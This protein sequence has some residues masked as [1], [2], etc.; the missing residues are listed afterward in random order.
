MS[1][2]E[3]PNPISIEIFERLCEAHYADIYYTV[4]F[5]T[6]DPVLAQDGVQQAFIKAFKQFGTLRK[7]EKFPSWIVAIALNEIKHIK[8]RESYLKI[9]PIES[10]LHKVA[11]SDD[12]LDMKIDVQ[13]V[14]SK[15]KD[16][17]AEI[18]VLKYFAD[19]PVT[20]ISEI[21]EISEHNVKQRLHRARLKYR[22][23]TGAEIGGDYHGVF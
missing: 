7:K 6:K 23:L 10:S 4:C 3:D 1:N 13:G 19:L 16:H 20:Q 15:L 21:L 2:T 17:E 14:L 22:E 5:I 8:K 11:A 12:D 18:L 9:V